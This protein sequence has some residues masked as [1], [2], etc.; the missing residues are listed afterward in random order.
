VRGFYQ[1]ER[2]AGTDVIPHLIRLHRWVA[3]L[4]VGCSLGALVSPGKTQRWP[5]PWPPPPG[6][7]RVVIDADAANEID[8]QYALAQALGFPERLKI[9][10]LIAAHYGDFGGSAGIE[11]SYR[12]IQRVLEKAGLA[13]T[14][15]VKRGSEPFAFADRPPD[16]EGVRFII[17]RAM[18]G[19][20]ENPLWLVMLGPATNGVAALKLEPRI[21][22]RVVFFWHGRTQ[23]PARCWNFNVF[24]DVKAARLLFESEARFILFDTGTFLIISQEE[25]RRRFAPLGALGGYLHAIR[26]RAPAYLLPRK[27]MWDLGDTTALLDPS[28]VR[29]ERVQAPAVGYDLSYN[30]KRKLGEIVRIHEVNRERAFDLLERALQR[31]QAMSAAAPQP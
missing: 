12:E 11:E 14:I 22:D 16:S 3:A 20:P 15:P 21:A 10:G 17:E 19:T 18:Q 29:F 13:G 23:W 9:E 2:T 8:D 27:S 30:F 1:R 5:A 25:T 7:L 24:N 4:T 26:A 6:P 31:V 28:A